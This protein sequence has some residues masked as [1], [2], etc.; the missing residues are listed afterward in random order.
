M[1]NFIRAILFLLLSTQAL[2]EPYVANYVIYN[3][4]AIELI[5][6][7]V[8]TMYDGLGEVIYTAWEEA[9]LELVTPDSPEEYK[10]AGYVIGWRP[11][12]ENII[13]YFSIDNR[14]T[15]PKSE[16][17]TIILDRP[18]FEEKTIDTPVLPT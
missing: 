13:I 5:Y 2:A 18:M 4:K 1:K 11:D 3:G 14:V 6:G 8:A 17:K 12:K 16:I 9:G 10:K 7:L 15:I